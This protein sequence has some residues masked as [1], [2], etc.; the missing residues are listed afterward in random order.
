MT[1]LFLE[2]LSAFKWVEHS[3][4]VS[5]LLKEFANISFTLLGSLKTTKNFYFWVVWMILLRVVLGSIPHVR[6][7]TWRMV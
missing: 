6:L 5:F 4:N 7:F 1:Y 2:L 3:S